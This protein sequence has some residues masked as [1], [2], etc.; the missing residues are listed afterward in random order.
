MMAGGHFDPTGIIKGHGGHGQT[1]QMDPHGDLPDITADMH[2]N[3]TTAVTSGKLT[4]AQVRGRSIM[5]HR[6]GSADP[7]KP[8]GGGPRYACGVMPH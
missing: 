5:V 3:A 1:H 2:G 6:Y 8:A 7:G 4:V